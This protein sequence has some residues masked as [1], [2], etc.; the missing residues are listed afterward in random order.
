[1]RS[2]P[3]RGCV[4]TGNDGCDGF[5]VH[6]AGELFSAGKRCGRSSTLLLQ[7]TGPPA[8]A[9]RRGVFLPMTRMTCLTMLLLLV[10]TGARAEEWP[11]WRGP[12]GDGT[13]AET[14]LPVR[15]SAN[16]NVAWKATLPGIGHSSP[17]VWGDRVFVTTCV[18][19][20]L[21]RVLLC[22]DRRDG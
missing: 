2:V 18:Q 15:W 5:R 12:R 1:M 3:D 4:C 6:A 21:Q 14:G 10:P 11:G 16:E 22:L 17:I 13:S 8:C 9:S 19:P 20:D 7:R